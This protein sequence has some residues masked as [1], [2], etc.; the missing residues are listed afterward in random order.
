M[1]PSRVVI[2]LT[3]I[4][5]C[6]PVAFA[7][8]E[9][10][11]P[12]PEQQAVEALKRIRT[13]IQFNKD[14]TTR[15]L[16]LSNATV[17][18]DALAHLQHFKQLDYLAI[19]CPQ[20][21]DANTNHIAG[22][23]N[24]ET[25]LLSKS[26]IGDAT[27][28]HLTG[29]EKLERLY[30]AETKISDEGLANIAGLLQ[31]TSLSLEQTDISDEG[32]KHLRGLSNIETLLLNET[33]VTGP[34]LTELQELSQLRVLYLEQCALDSSAILNLEPIKSL[35]HL[36]LN[37]VAL[38]DEMIA[39]FA[40]LSQL[41]VVELYR[42]GCS[43]GGLEALRAALPNAQFYIDPELVVAERQTRRTELHSVPDGLRTHPT[44]D[45]EG[46]RLT[47][48]ADRLAEA[49]EPPDFQKHV[50]PLLGRLGCN[51]RACH[52]SFQGQGGFRLS[53][54]GY[55]FEMDHGN[56]SERIDL[57]S[58][59]DSL[60]L[61][62]PTSADEHEGGLRLPPGGWEQ[63]LLRRWIE[64]G[65]K[66]VG[67]NPPTFVRLDVTPTEIVFKRSDEAVQL[68]AEAVWSDGTRE[69]V[70]CLT[71]FQTNDETVAKVSPEGIVQTC[72]TG[73]TYIV[74]FYDNGIHSTQ[75]LRPVSDLTG[76]VYPDVPTPT[77]ID[78]LVVEKLAK[79]GIVPSEL[80]SDEEFLRR[81]SLDI[82]GTLP[83]PK[84]IG[85]FVTDTSPDKRSRK[86]D[87]LLDHPA[88]VTWWTTRLC[89]LTGSNAGYL[90]AT[91]MA[92]PVAAQWRAWIERRVQENVGWDKI[93]SG[94][95]LARSRAPGQPYREFIA[96][97]SEYTNTV[98]PADFAA[99]DNSMPHF[100]YRDNINQPTDKALAFGY[101]FLGVRLDCA[102]CHKH[103]YDQWSKR[104]FELFT[105]FFT[106]IKAGVPPD[107]KPLHEATQH[108]LGVPVKLN[109]AALR[110][111]SYLR[112]A[113]EGRPIPW[114][115]VY[116]EPAKGE[117]PGKL[118]GGPEIDLSQ[119]DDPREPLM[120]WLLTE[121][122]HYFAKSFVNRIWTNYFNVGII[123]PP[124]D[125][126]LAN[127]PSNKALLDHL[128]DGFI[129]S[130][131]DM[132]W[133]HRTIANS[134]TYQLSW[135]PND[136]NRADTR[137]FSHAVLRRLPAE[138]AIDAINQATAS[139]EV[140]GAVEMAVGNRKIG[141]HPVS[142][143]TRAIDF[144][145]LIFGKP[146]RT[147]NCDCERQ[148]S[149]NLLQSLYTRN[150]Q[151]MLDTLG[152]RNGWIAQLEKEKPTAD[153][154][155]ELVAS[156]YL[157]A[158]SREPTASEAADCRQHIE[159]SES[160]VEGLR[161]LLWALLN[162]QEFITNH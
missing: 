21:T 53:M 95:L 7:A 85:S 70:T 51:G 106:R 19:V 126:N 96:E 31:L 130:G 124:D 34:G 143:Q 22:L 90:G 87:E 139:D 69:D 155:E 162:T 94:I 112:I 91:E 45:D 158:L 1:R 145:L 149:P 154:I 104:D 37:G 99:L 60:I 33:Q 15:L 20:V 42:T 152:R 127:P 56:L 36:S 82:I 54:F 39:S 151:E 121:P 110:R 38:T 41:K 120:E 132:K 161:D 29:L 92:Q 125:L 72:G 3:A 146:L 98:E 55:D 88:Y 97:Q 78:R 107:A 142:Y 12:S 89:D 66:G 131:Y 103:P 67:E 43:L 157:R 138:V 123:D 84:E 48:I 4:S 24:L 81:V 30:L 100:W 46:P 148:S 57:D 25:L 63:K 8:D 101:T 17:T 35:E 102:Q 62:K 18:D 136:T 114:N 61:N 105:E 76:D 75:V 122:N 16:R 65:A 80:S 52:G 49:D 116:I 77:E 13:N 26:S 140:L 108:M 153:R 137:N 133:L 144:S 118:L 9:V 71:R 113:A 14:G 109:T 159:Q 5:L 10:Q 64:A 156:A 150:D 119:F 50:I 135:R 32:L 117:Q 79:L 73:D 59:D 27:L 93:A 115:E 141:Q 28:A 74:S 68:K 11:A 40:K 2:I 86:I 129:G 160:I 58:P 147:T 23:I 44:N 111:Q 128:T 134:R 83:T 47:A 6:S